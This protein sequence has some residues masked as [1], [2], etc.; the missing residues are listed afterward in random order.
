MNILVTTASK[1]G[2]TGEI[3]EIIAGVLR[4]AG[5]EVETRPPQEVR[6]LEAY[7]AVILGSGVY[8]GRWLGA[9]RELAQ[10]LESD[11]VR[12]PVWLFSSGPIGDP[13]LPEGDP[14]EALALADRLQ[15]RG[16]RTL[17]GRLD[18]SQLGFMERTVTK[19][20]KAADG[21]Y[22]DPEAIRRWADQIAVALKAEEVAA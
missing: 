11:L 9:A 7:D 14:A 10:R 16:H 18:R 17:A 3:G 4:D 13:A 20:V 19:V 5:H 15:A 21:D 12:K 8:A 2:A 1:H 22:R 6:T